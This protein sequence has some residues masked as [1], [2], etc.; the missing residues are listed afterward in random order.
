MR[1]S[2]PSYKYSNNDSCVSAYV[3]ECFIAVLRET[4]EVVFGNNGVYEYGFCTLSN[5]E[6]AIS[7]IFELQ[8]E[9]TLKVTL[10]GKTFYYKAMPM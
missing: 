7:N 9:G 4:N 5:I 2:D 1:Y 10:D 6:Q 8:D 3:Y